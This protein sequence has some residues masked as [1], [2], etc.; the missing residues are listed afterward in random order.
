MSARKVLAFAKAI[1]SIKAQDV[2]T[3]FRI[4]DYPHLKKGERKRLFD[5]YYRKA[6]PYD[7]KR[8]MKVED[9]MR[10]CKMRG[11]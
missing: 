2:I 5:F 4:A 8:V 1:D 11:Y 3:E 6:F 7:E 9:F 10:H